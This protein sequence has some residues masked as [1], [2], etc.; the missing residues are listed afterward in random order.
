PAPAAPRVNAQIQIQGGGQLQIQGGAQ[1]QLQ[2]GGVRIQAVAGS[3]APASVAKPQ[4]G[5]LPVIFFPGIPFILLPNPAAQGDA[6]P[7]YLGVQL[8]TAPVAQADAAVAKEKGLAKKNEGVL[9][10]TVI[11]DSPAAKAGMEE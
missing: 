3:A 1:F 5:E 11:D 8:E 10:L 7:G 2:L 6:K 9:I 4:T